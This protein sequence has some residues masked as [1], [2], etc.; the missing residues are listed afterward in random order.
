LQPL[1]S[2]AM[3]APHPSELHTLYATA[4]PGPTAPVSRDPDMATL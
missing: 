2:I 4:K 3:A 1:D